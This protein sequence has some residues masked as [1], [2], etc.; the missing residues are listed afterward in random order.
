MVAFAIPS[1]GILFKCRANGDPLELEFGSF[2]SLLKFIRTSLK[3][4]KIDNIKVHSSSPEFVFAFTPNSKHMAEGSARKKMLLEYV[5]GIQVAISYVEQYKNK[6]R[7]ALLDYPSVPEGKRAV[8]QPDFNE[9][10]KT[11]FKP[12]QRGVKL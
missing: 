1:L 4:E 12:F 10:K 2:F 6:V 9:T 8:L 11:S 7:V 5:K 3:E